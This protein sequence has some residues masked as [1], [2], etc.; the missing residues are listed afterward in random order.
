MTEDIENGSTIVRS[1]IEP[2]LTSS[3][4]ERQIRELSSS[5]KLA[6]IGGILALTSSLLFTFYGLFIKKFHMNFVDTLFVRSLIQTPLL[7]LFVKIRGQ[8]LFV[9]EFSEDTTRVERLK[10]YFVLIGQGVLAGLNM[11]CSYLGVLYIP[12]GDALT[13]IYTAPIF[14]MIFS[15]IF[16]RIRQGFWKMSLDIILMIGVI[17]VIRPPFMFPQNTPKLQFLQQSKKTNQT[18]MTGE[19]KSMEIETFHWM[20][21]AMSLGA[22]CIGGLMNVSINYLKEVDSGTV[23]FWNGLMSIVC[24]FAFLSFDQNSL[25]FFDT[26]NVDLETVGKLAALASIGIC[27]NWMSTIS[28]QLL[29]PTFCAVLRSQEVIF[30]YIA[31]MIVFHVIPCNISFIGAFLVLS[32]AVCMPLEKFVKPRLPERIRFLF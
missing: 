7:I 30:A 4:K 16:L 17:L 2:I 1:D 10:K 6:V 28:Y 21:V 5:K 25:I 31:Q 29:D 9:L 12:L 11:M 8:N 23:Y 20:G 32:S 27:S 15:Y 22:S 13:I 19:K 3:S 14:T 24:S 18:L 26:K